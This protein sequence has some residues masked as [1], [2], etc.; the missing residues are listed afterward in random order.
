MKI[1]KLWADVNNYDSLMAMDPDYDYTEITLDGHS[2]ADKWE[3][4]EL[5]RMYGDGLLLSDFPHYYGD[6]V[7]SEKAINVL[8]P[9]I[10]DSVEYLKVIFD[11]KNYTMLNITKVLNVIDYE[12][13]EYKRFTSSGRIMRF[14]KYNFRMCDELL[15]SDIFKL[16]DEPRRNPFVSDRFKQYVE[17][18][19][20]TGFEFELVWDSE[21]ENE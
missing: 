20:L 13:S 11:E 16:I 5:K 21:A 12:K 1:W 3:P 10:N 19:N 2:M 15:T 14:I 18:N 9:L 17:D 4:V 7:M 6:P 8:S